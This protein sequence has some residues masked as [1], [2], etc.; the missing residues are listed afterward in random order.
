MFDGYGMALT[1]LVTS[2][3]AGVL[4]SLIGIERER[5]RHAAGL[6]THVVITIACSLMMSISIDAVN[7]A[8]KGIGRF[9]S[10]SYDASLFA[11]SILA[12][13]GFMGAGTIVKNGLSMR[14]LTR[15]STILLC[16]SIG[17]A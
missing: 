6:R 15:A 2:F 17:I 9:D 4:S 11:A 14:G 13:I 7:L 16:A 8:T 10:L 5:K 12:G 3:I 1:V